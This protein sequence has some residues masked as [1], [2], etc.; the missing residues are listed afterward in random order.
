[1]LPSASEGKRD[2]RRLF[3]QLKSDKR[4]RAKMNRGAFYGVIA[5]F[6]WFKLQLPVLIILLVLLGLYAAMGGY[7]YLNVAART[8]KRDLT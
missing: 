7:E 6:L 5:S 4:E 8:I 2:R 1:L 3:L